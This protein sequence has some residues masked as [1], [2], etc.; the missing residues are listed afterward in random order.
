MLVTAPLR[1]SDATLGYFRAHAIDAEVAHEV[2]VREVDG[3]LVFT[4]KAADGS[5]FERRRSLNGSGPAKVLQAAGQPLELWWLRGRPQDGDMALLCEGESDALAALS[6]LD[7]APVEF[8]RDLPVAALPGTGFPPDRLVGALSACGVGEV[9]LA[10]DGD[11]AGRAYERRAAECLLAAGIRTRVLELPDGMDLAEQLA[12]VED[13]SDWLANAVVDAAPAGEPLSERGAGWLGSAATLLAGPDPGPTPF[14]VDQL[15]VDGA[16]AAIQGSHKVGKTWLLLEIAVAIVTGRPVLGHYAIPNPG[17]VMLVLEESGETA[18]HR[19]LAALARGYNLR[20][21]DLAGLHYAAN[22]RVRLDEEG[23][24]ERLVERALALRPRAIFLD[25]LVRV[26][27]AGVDENAQREMAPVLDFLRDLRDRASALVGFTHHTGHEGRWLRGS[28]DLEA[29]WESKLT[30][31]RDVGGVLELRAEHRE[32]ESGE[33]ARYRLS[34]HQ[35]SRSMRLSPLDDPAPPQAAP[36]EVLEYVLAHPGAT[37]AEVAS[38]AR[39][40]KERT[41]SRL[42][43]L[44]RAGTVYRERGREPDRMGRPRERE[45]WYPAPEAGG[46][47]VPTDGTLEDREGPWAADGPEA[48]PLIEGGPGTATG[49]E[50]GAG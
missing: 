7:A 47:E 32:A 34:F 45:G 8:L 35:P 12:R 20:G 41:R 24:H 29:Y 49:P 21:E 4:C 23:W 37:L 43:E 5:T 31:S 28:S 16:I 48:P 39:R 11:A 3:Q 46:S 14:L 25:P 50:G 40:R 30:L 27:G 9:V 13:R 17:P 18:L 1:Y 42:L 44:E 10:L 36:D 38:G 33:R 22:R 6:A 15:L 19:R 2:G 26:K